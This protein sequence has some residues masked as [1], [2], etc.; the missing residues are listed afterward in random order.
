MDKQTVLKKLSGRVNRMRASNLKEISK[1]ERIVKVKRDSHYEE[2]RIE[3]MKLENTKLQPRTVCGLTYKMRDE[4]F[5]NATGTCEFNPETMY[6]HSYRW[7][8]LVKRIKGTVVLNDYRYSQQTS[9]H[10]W[11][12]RDVLRTLGIKFVELEAPRG[13]QN[14]DAA[15][16]YELETQA[17]R[18]IASKYGRDKRKMKYAIQDTKALKLLA[19]LGFKA[20][21]KMKSSA[22][23]TAEQ[24]RRDKNERAREESKMRRAV[25]AL[26]LE[27]A[28][29]N[30]FSDETA[31]HI[32]KSSDWLWSE[33]GFNFDRLN[34]WEKRD[35]VRAG[36]TKIMVHRHEK[37]HLTLA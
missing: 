24:N 22:L 27:V 7:Y 5:S 8:D 28:T 26:K 37:R 20:S 19:R 11:K 25:Q 14:L 17:A 16:A 3:R 1:L 21:K 29:P 12:T 15:L 10:I 30:D 36:K 13:L 2:Q 18:V 31:H 4:I 35:A 6:A 32:V 9:G 23:E 33:N 34:D